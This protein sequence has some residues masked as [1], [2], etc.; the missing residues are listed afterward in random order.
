MLWQLQPN[1]RSSKNVL[2]RPAKSAR[3]LC[4][5]SSTPY[6]WP[7]HQKMLSMCFLR[8]LTLSHLSLLCLEL[9]SL[10]MSSSQGLLLLPEVSPNSQ[11][12][13]KLLRLCSATR[14]QLFKIFTSSSTSFVNKLI[15]PLLPPTPMLLPMCPLSLG[16]VLLVG[17][18][19]G[20]NYGGGKIWISSDSTM[21]SNADNMDSRKFI[22]IV[23]KIVMRLDRE[24]NYSYKSDLEE[25]RWIYKKVVCIWDVDQWANHSNV[26]SRIRDQEWSGRS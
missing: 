9:L 26:K 22:P 17:V 11:L 4:E 13:L 7:V 16:S 21:L 25:V 20:H 1:G 2:S 19:G 10:T 24:L 12:Q 23:L 15:H 3:V 6:I 18:V 14:L 8:N 5:P